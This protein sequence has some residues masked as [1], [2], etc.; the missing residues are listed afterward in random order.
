MA[1]PFIGE[2]RIFPYMFAPR[3]WARCDGTLAHVTELSSL[4]KILG[5]RY[6]G[7]GKITFALPDLQGRVP[8]GPG[9]GPDLPS[10][11]L[12]EMGGS[13]SVVLVDAQIPEHSH[14]IAKVFTDA[15]ALQ[16]PAGAYLG[17]MK[18]NPFYK[19][20]GTVVTLTQMSPSALSVTG[21]SLPHE[22]RQPYLAMQFCIAVDGVYPIRA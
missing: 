17:K 3:G 12:G 4:F 6:G 11:Q 10:Y 16:N 20:R 7:D 22:N 15:P 9:Q 13:S 8:V 2:I 14:T 5:T 1:K 18:G 21:K 19:T